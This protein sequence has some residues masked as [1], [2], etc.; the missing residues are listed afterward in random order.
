MYSTIMEAAPLLKVSD[1]AENLIGSEIIKLAGEVKE[2]ISNGEKIYNYTIG[3]FDPE[4]FPIPIDLKEEIIKAYQDGHTN[5]PAANGMLELRKSVS[6]YLHTRGGIEYNENQILIAGGARPLIYAIYQTLLDK[7]DTVVFPTP[8]WNNNHYCHIT[9][10]KQVKIEGAPENNFMPTAKDI[11]PYISEAKLIALCSPLNPTGT[12]FSE[13]G[14]EEICDLILEENKKRGEQKKPVYLLFDQIYWQLTHGLT[15]HCD[16]VSL[17]PRMKNY[18]I[19]VDGIS[20]AFAS[21]GVRVGWAFGPQKVIDKMRS[22]CGH[23]GAWSPKAEQI[24]C[25]NY[26]M[27]DNSVDAYLAEIKTKINQRLTGFYDGFSNLKSQGY[28]VNAIAPQAAMYLTVKISIQG[29]TTPSGE[30][31]TTAEAVTKYL[32]NEAKIALVP[33]YAFGASKKSSWYR[34]SVGTAKMEEIPGFFGNL[35]M[36]LDKLS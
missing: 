14:L 27:K 12:T 34:L 29:S 4:L 33:F 32:L 30:K 17:R 26:L 19:Y 2:K 6:R 15:I 25:A 23:I 35:K 3:D 8:S 22:I 20:K 18:T 9:G 10:A 5:Y 1:M 21:T 13:K 36:A 24:A 28:R 31:L 7:N 11:K 16:P